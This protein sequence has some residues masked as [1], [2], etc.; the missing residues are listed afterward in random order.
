MSAGE[1]GSLV[2]ALAGLLLLSYPIVNLTN[3][4]I[5]VLGVPLLYFYLFAVW[6]A[7]VGV[8]WLLSRNED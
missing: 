2:A 4:P 6:F 8:A 5:L 7:G 3:V 1:R